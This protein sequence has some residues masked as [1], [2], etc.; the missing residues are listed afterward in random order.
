MPV[1]IA[2]QK[3]LLKLSAELLSLGRLMNS[4]EFSMKCRLEYFS[5]R[6]NYDSENLYEVSQP[7]SCSPNAPRCQLIEVN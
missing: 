2:L 6:L 5:N 4:D 3:K 7:T 1:D